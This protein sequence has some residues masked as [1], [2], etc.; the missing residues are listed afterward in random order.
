MGFANRYLEAY[1][2]YKADKPVTKSW[3]LAFD[4][5]NDTKAIVLQHLF[6]GMNAHI[7]L[8]LG[9]VASE[10]SPGDEIH[11]LKGDF[12]K[13]NEVLGSLVD[14]VESE[15]GRIWAFLKFIDRFAGRLD[16]AIAIFSIDIARKKAWKVATDLAAINDSKGRKNYI[17]N[18]D[19]KVHKFGCKLYRPGI[20]LSTLVRIIRLTEKGDVAQRIEILR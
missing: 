20:I 14:E 12:N 11:N 16:E 4:A 19:N 13:I 9:I 5:A 7:N 10:I 18:K 17:A 15:L 6:L 2:N 8:D 3:Q 1:D